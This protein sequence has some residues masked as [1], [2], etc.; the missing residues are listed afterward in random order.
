VGEYST[1]TDWDTLFDEW[2]LRTYAPLQSEEDAEEMALGAARL[3]GVEP[4][5][6]VLDAPC[7]FGRHSLAL[8]RAGFQVT[9]ADRSPVLLDEARR[10]GEGL[11]VT[12]VQADYREL[13]VPDSSF[14]VVLNLFSSLGYVGREGDVQALGEF[15]RVLRRGGC[16]V[17]ES[18]HRDR[19]A[20]IFQSKG[21]DELPGDGYLLQERT[22]DPVAG[23]VRTTMQIVTPEEQPTFTYEIR[24]YCV[25]ELVEMVREAGFEQVDCYGGLDGSELTFDSRLVLVAG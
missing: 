19:L 22:F 18:M 21:W 13:P 8:A 14:D 17:I 24:L 4:G 6:D 12:W 23:T 25:T 9:G 15:R 1:V 20:R 7:G 16:L 3:A 10:R 11:G 2:Y 5:A